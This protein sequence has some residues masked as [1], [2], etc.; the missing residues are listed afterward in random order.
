MTTGVIYSAGCCSHTQLGVPR[1]DD[2]ATP[3]NEASFQRASPGVS[4]AGDGGG[5]FLITLGMWDN[6]TGTEFVQKS[7]FV[8][9]FG[10]TAGLR[11]GGQEATAS[12]AAVNCKPSYLSSMNYLFQVRGLIGRPARSPP[13][14]TRARTCSLRQV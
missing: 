6:S 12:L 9:E 11:H 13:S 4:D 3:A 7:T 10:H 5:D 8:H 2:P 14:T 1:D